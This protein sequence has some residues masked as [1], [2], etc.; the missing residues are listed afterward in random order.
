MLSAY[1]LTGTTQEYV[2]VTSLLQTLLNTK[3][4]IQYVFASNG[5]IVV[6]TKPLVTCVVILSIRARRVNM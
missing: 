2:I 5:F 6:Y 3:S 1:A 4:E